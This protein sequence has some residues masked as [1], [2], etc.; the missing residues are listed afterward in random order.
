MGEVQDIF[1]NPIDFLA[2]PAKR[3]TAVVDCRF[4]AFITKQQQA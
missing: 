3:K 2:I 1:S 4:F